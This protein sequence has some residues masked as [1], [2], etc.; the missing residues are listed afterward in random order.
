[1]TSPHDNILPSKI[2]SIPKSF[3]DKTTYTHDTIL[4]LKFDCALKISNDE[5]ID[6]HDLFLE[7]QQ[8]F[9]ISRQIFKIRQYFK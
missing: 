2:D 1:M 7:A 3:N 9:K 6:S 4:F 8:C 5:R